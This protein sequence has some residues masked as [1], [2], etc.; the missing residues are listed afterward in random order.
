MHHPLKR[1]LIAGA[2][3]KM[4]LG[5][6]GFPA[7]GQCRKHAVE[8]MKNPY[9][10]CDAFIKKVKIYMGCDVLNWAK[11]RYVCVWKTKISGSLFFG[12]PTIPVLFL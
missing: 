2:D 7:Q 1:I 3:D 8:R 12:M 5:K 10:Y 4:V 11:Q 9:M 6:D